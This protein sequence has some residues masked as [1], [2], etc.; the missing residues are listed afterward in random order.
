[1][2]K[3]EELKFSSDVV[4]RFKKFAR[5]NCPTESRLNL[6]EFDVFSMRNGQAVV[7]TLTQAVYSQYCFD[8]VLDPSTGRTTQAEKFKY[9]IGYI[10]KNI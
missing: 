9:L 5:Q 6:V 3:L 8:H 1:M 7:D 2:E 4:V 10:Q